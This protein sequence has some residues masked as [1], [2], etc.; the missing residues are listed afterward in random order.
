MP[1]MKGIEEYNI[2][3]FKTYDFKWCIIF[4]EVTWYC[5]VCP[6]SRRLGEVTGLCKPSSV[7]CFPSSLNYQ[8]G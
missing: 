7:S 8:L 1:R 5:A 3:S 2:H 6:D 4:N